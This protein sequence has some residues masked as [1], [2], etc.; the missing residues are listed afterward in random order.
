MLEGDVSR[1]TISARRI[2]NGAD[3]TGDL[4]AHAKV[5]SAAGAKP[6]ARAKWKGAA[7]AVVHTLDASLDE[8]KVDAVVDVPS[9]DAAAIRTLWP[10]STIKETAAAH[11]EAHG[12]L[13]NI[14][15]V[16]HATM[17]PSAVDANAKLVAGDE[18]KANVK[19]TVRNMDVHQFAASVPTSRLGLDASV[20]ANMSAAGD[21]SGKVTLVFQ[22][23]TVGAQAIPPAD[24][25]ADGSRTAKNVMQANLDL[26]VKEP[27]APTHLA[28]HLKPNMML[29]FILDANAT[30][31]DQIPELR[32]SV[33]GSARVSGNGEIDVDKMTVDAEV[34]AAA[35]DIVQGATRVGAASVDVEAQGP[36]SAPRFEAAVDGRDITAGGL[37]F[38]N[39]RA[40]AMGHPEALHVE[41][42]ARGPDTPDVAASVNVVQKD[43]LLLEAPHVTLTRGTEHALVEADNVRIDGANIHVDGARIERNR[44]TE[45]TS[46]SMAMSPGSSSRSRVDQGG[47][48]LARIGRLAHL[49][50]DLRN[51]TV[52]FDVDLD[53]RHGTANGQV[54]IKVADAQIADVRGLSADIDTK[55][56]DRKFA[57]KVHAEA[58]DIGSID[59]DAPA[60]QIGTEGAL[61][62]ASWRNACSETFAAIDAKADLAKVT[63]LVPPDQAPLDEAGGQIELH[64]HIQRDDQHDLTPGLTIALVTH[65]LVVTPKTAVQRDADG[66]VVIQPA[67]WKLSGVDFKVDTSIDGK[68]GALK[69]AAVVSDAKGPI[70]NLDVD[71]PHLPYRDVFFNTGVL[72]QD[73]EKT[74]F[75]IK[76]VV[77]ER[78]L[79]SLPA[80]LHQ[81]F[82]TGKLKADVSVMGT[83][84]RPDVEV[85]AS[86]AKAHGNSMRTPLDLE[87][88]AHYD[89]SKGDATIT[90]QSQDKKLLDAK[91]TVDAPWDPIVTGQGAP[92]WV[93]SVKAHLDGFPIQSVTALHDKMVEGL[94]SGDITLDELHKDAKA[95]A[96]ISVASLSVGSVRYK[97]AR[98]QFTAD[99]K[100]LDADAR[101]DQVDG[102]AEAKG[103]ANATWGNA[104]APVP[105]ASRPVGASL[106]SKNFRL[107]A[108]LPFVDSI[109]DEL[110]GRIDSEARVQL[111]QKS[112]GAK[113]SGHVGLSRG[114]IEAVAGGGE[115]HDITGNV[116]FTPDGNI[117]IE[118]LTGSGLTGRFNATGSAHLEGTTLKTAKLTLDIPKKQGIPINGGGT[119]IGTLD[120]RIQVEAVGGDRGAM[121]VTVDVPQLHVALPQATTTNAQALGPMAKVSI[122]T[123]RGRRD[124]FVVIALDPVDDTKNKGASSGGGLILQ[125][126]LRDIEVT[127]GNDLKIDLTGKLTVNAGEKTE[128]KG[129]IQLERRR[130]ARGPGKELHHREGN[131]VLRGRRPGQ[132]GDRGD[133]RLDGPRWHGGLCRLRRAFEDGEGHA[134]FR[135]RTP[136]TGDRA[137]SLVRSA[138]RYPGPTAQRRGAKLD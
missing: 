85:S 58:K 43:G 20:V 114:T 75:D 12:T 19:L 25:Q 50:K 76:L 131:R 74:D 90:A 86:L 52:D 91:G 126:N 63:Q 105:D 79:A 130:L 7:G 4:T 82:V 113:L 53:V 125:T 68:T 80:T 94:V 103:H 71:A 2:A 108:L 35:N 117:T 129:Q 13:P 92:A 83:M 6:S 45:N 15:V 31:L 60:L 127:R 61:S 42:A 107:V 118:K 27:G 132:P 138:R 95:K 99:G 8:D 29:G 10:A 121:K 46:A 96:D 1:A 51:G 3:V 57:G 41:V 84:M 98:I 34:H 135:A 128:V 122:G 33:R 47:M 30:D 36:L 137:A 65:G 40:R 9:A 88:K 72:M 55:L 115:F 49:E 5:P 97:G 69:F 124:A 100:V 109:F 78:D 134:A 28:A 17:G 66:I 102:F 48:D 37:R 81:D 14:D 64:A 26:Q 119:E 38:T 59:V 123:H 21:A 44:R 22:G 101:I 70:A 73:L 120:G 23:G 136:A 54:T 87:V 116:V 104:M 112:N 32:R 39:I 106:S 16:L 93:A 77:P 11:V 133:R 56:D 67:P 110:D 111:D 89:G 18:K 62:A 24:I